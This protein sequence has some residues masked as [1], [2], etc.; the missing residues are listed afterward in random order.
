M[1]GLFGSLAIVVALVGGGMA[2]AGLVYWNVIMIGANGTPIDSA[3]ASPPC[4]SCQHPYTRSLSRY[5]YTCE[6]CQRKFTCRADGR[7]WFVY[8]DE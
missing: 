2:V 8:G 7:N 3:G 5:G 6:K 1:R 4:P